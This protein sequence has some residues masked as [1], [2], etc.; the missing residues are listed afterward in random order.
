MGNFFTPEEIDDLSIQVDIQLNELSQPVISTPCDIRVDNNFFGS[1]IAYELPFSQRQNIEANVRED[2]EIFLQRF[3]SK[4][5]CQNNLKMEKVILLERFA[6]ILYEM[7]FFGVK[8]Q[9]VD[10]AITV[11]ILHI[12]LATFTD[13]YCTS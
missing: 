2:A 9:I 11:Y 6:K 3:A 8:L 5:I 12:G 1:A 10:I 7:G 13:K 4:T